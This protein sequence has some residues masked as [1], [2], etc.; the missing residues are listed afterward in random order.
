[1]QVFRGVSFCKG[2]GLHTDVV[3][4]VVLCNSGPVIMVGALMIDPSV[5]KNGTRVASVQMGLRETNSF[6]LPY[7]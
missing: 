4:E 3:S 6:S 2:Q 7:D 5:T 1:M